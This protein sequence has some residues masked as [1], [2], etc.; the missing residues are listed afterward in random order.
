VA[1]VG[2]TVRFRVVIKNTGDTALTDVRIVDEYPPAYFSI[3]APADMRQISGV[4]TKTIQRLERGQQEEYFVD[5]RCL[6]AKLRD[7]EPPLVRVD[8]QTD[9]PSTTVPGAAEAQLEIRPLNAPA[10]GGI[11]PNAGA[12][13]AG[14]PG[15]RPP[16]T[17]T[18][19][20]NPQTARVNTVVN[21][22]VAVVNSS[23]VEDQDVALRLVLPPQLVPD[24]DRIQPPDNVQRTWDA[25]RGQL[26][27]SPVATL[28]ATK[29][30]IFQIPLTVQG[31]PGIVNVEADVRSRNSTLPSP[32][33][34]QLEITTL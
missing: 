14:A 28:Q 31:Q 6:Q 22:E 2:E 27:F 8:A 26:S 18:T 11:D 9:P 10:G 15:T 4:L 32:R 13:G 19:I 29:R 25:A 21:C 1:A 24:M 23:M 34:T 17:V 3:R 5:A 20:F 16:L 7:I 12:G 30:V 33:R